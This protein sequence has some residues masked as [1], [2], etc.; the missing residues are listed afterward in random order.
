M[1][2]VQPEKDIVDVKHL[3]AVGANEHLGKTDDVAG[4]F[5]AS[6]AERPDGAELLAPWTEEEEKKVLRKADMIVLPLMAFAL[7]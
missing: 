2:E 7:T 1:S 3:P 5:I 4:R 6:I